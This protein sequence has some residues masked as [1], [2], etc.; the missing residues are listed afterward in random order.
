MPKNSPPAA[1]AAAP[2]AEVTPSS[3]ATFDLTPGPATLPGPTAEAD[4]TV[5]PLAALANVDSVRPITAE[6]VP[7]PERRAPEAW[8]EQ[9]RV[10]AWQLNAARARHT[11]DDGRELDDEAARVRAGWLTNGTLTE[12][13]FDAALDLTLNGSLR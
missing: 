13:Q 11:V 6:V 8:A 9:K 5:V 10:P 1:P 2:A 3:E 12:A 4:L 7:E